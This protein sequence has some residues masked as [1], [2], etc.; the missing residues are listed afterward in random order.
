MSTPYLLVAVV[1]I[2]VLKRGGGQL[3]GEACLHSD[4][5]RGTL[6]Q[7]RVR[8][9]ALIVVL[10]IVSDLENMKNV[11]NINLNLTRVSQEKLRYLMLK[12]VY[13]GLKLL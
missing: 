6:L 4:G 5:D 7:R 10:V 3:G 8:L 2:D 11:S 1:G 9:R 13:L 12:T